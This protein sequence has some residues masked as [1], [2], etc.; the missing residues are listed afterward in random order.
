MPSVILELETRCS[1]EAVADD[2][3]GGS[4]T[5]RG[6]Q[7]HKSRGPRYRT[8]I[9]RR[10]GQEEGMCAMINKAEKS[11]LK[12]MPWKI[13]VRKLRPVREEPER[14]F[15]TQTPTRHLCEDF[16]LSPGTPGLFFKHS[17]TW[18]ILATSPELAGLSPRFHR[19]ISLQC[20]S[21]TF[22]YKL[23]GQKSPMKTTPNQTWDPF[24]VDTSTKI[25]LAP[26][27]R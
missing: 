2:G 16:S 17:L 13:N 14:G 7:N 24:P 3:P 11:F 23:K 26:R 18:S 22:C 15:T 19:I 5:N 6:G 1:G 9:R 21:V 20:Y 8:S 27:L 12:E 25:A 4:S 10:I